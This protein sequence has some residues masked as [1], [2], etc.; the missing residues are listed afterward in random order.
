[1]TDQEQLVDGVFEEFHDK[2]EVKRS[3]KGL[4]VYNRKSKKPVTEDTLI[5]DIKG[6]IG[7]DSTV[8]AAAALPKLQDLSIN[9]ADTELAKQQQL[10][11]SVE[12]H[13][14]NFYNKLTN[15]LNRCSVCSFADL[16]TVQCRIFPKDY[17]AW[18]KDSNTMKYGMSFDPKELKAALTTTYHEDMVELQ[19]LHVKCLNAVKTLDRQDDMRRQVELDL[20]DSLEKM[21]QLKNSGSKLIERH[22]DIFKNAP[23]TITD[24][25]NKPHY[26]LFSKE[27]LVS[28]QYPTWDE[29]LDKLKNPE[30]SR[31][32]L[33]IWIGGVFSNFK[34]C[35]Q[36]LWIQGEGGDGKSVICKA[37]C[38]ALGTAGFALGSLKSDHALIG[39]EAARLILADDCQNPKLLLHTKVKQLT[40]GASIKLNP[41]GQAEYTVTG[42]WRILINSNPLPE[43][44]LDNMAQASRLILLQIDPVKNAKGVHVENKQLQGD[45]TF[46][47]RIREEFPSFLHDCIELFEREILNH[48]KKIQNIPLPE[49]LLEEYHDII[50]LPQTEYIRDFM[51]THLEICKDDNEAFVAS[52]ELEREFKEYWKANNRKN[53]DFAFTSLREL[54]K[55]EVGP[56]DRKQQSGERRRGFYNVRLI[57][58]T[59]NAV[60]KINIKEDQ[61]DTFDEL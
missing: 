52:I 58:S 33:M 16:G 8:E 20:Q 46:E 45:G 30:S 11:N 27:H 40:G 2:Y 17:T 34:G 12:D 55:K 57:G 7:T 53:E 41:K 6:L 56:T 1:M 35:R 22:M 31:K 61:E 19:H 5:K 44:D 29:W 18:K 43:I 36:A 47:D 26:L 10:A 25:P 24:D 48:P 49:D 42:D 14:N 9:R 50:G 51:A 59:S 37:I 4:T 38:E 13:I 21:F 28:G 23:V 32:V 54:V 60:S 39:V 3:A 15:I